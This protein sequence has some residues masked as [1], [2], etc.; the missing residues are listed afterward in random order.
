MTVSCAV[1]LLTVVMFKRDQISFNP[2]DDEEDDDVNAGQGEEVLGLDVPRFNDEDEEEDDFEDDEEVAP[3]V[4]QRKLKAK[5]DNSTKGRFGKEDVSSD[6]YDDDEEED[7]EESGS[8]EEEEGW[9]RQYY[10]RPSTRRAKEKED[11]YDEKR[12]EERDMEEKEVRRLQRR[13]REALAEDDWGLDDVEV[14]YA[15]APTAEEE[16]AAPVPVPETSDPDTLIRHLQAHE[17]LKLALARD[18]PLVLHRLKKT[19][20]GIK[21]MSAEAEG[22]ESLHKG[23]GWLHYRELQCRNIKLTTRG[24]PDLRNYPR[25]LHPSLCSPRVGATGHDG[26][27]NS[28]SPLA[29]ERGCCR[30]GGPRLCRWISL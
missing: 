3:K 5:P 13:A 29:A 8:E 11:E 7:E 30:T 16:T 22:E 9:G 26:P 14:E 20:R 19:A 12:E 2:Q 25:I 1:A 6:D 18:F 21:K 24:S 10:S 28:R 23:L 17:P 4:K 27:P 15:A